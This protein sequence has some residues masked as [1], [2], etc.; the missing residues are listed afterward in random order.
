M[1]NKKILFLLFLTTLLSGCFNVEET[2][3]EIDTTLNSY[4]D[5]LLFEDVDESISYFLPSSTEYY[6]QYQSMIKQ[7][8]SSNLL[9]TLNNITYDS[10]TKDAVILKTEIHI[11]GISSEKEK[12]DKKIIHTIQM[13]ANSNGVWKINQLVEK[14]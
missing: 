9:F 2:K 3:T 14:K 8:N 12:I 11:T 6:S 7:F 5:S 4:Y 13:K 1:R 10:V